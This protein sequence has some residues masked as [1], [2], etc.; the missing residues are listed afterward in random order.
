MLNIDGS[1]IMNNNNKHEKMISRSEQKR[2]ET[3]VC[4]T[5]NLKMYRDGLRLSIH[6]A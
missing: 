3:M 1:S 4:L 6:L 2:H 5:S